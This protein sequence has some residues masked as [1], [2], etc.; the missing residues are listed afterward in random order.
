MTQSRWYR[1]FLRE[2]VQTVLTLFALLAMLG[3][4]S[5]QEAAQS[6]R[7]LNFQSDIT[8]RTDGTVRVRETIEVYA[9]GR[10]IQRGIYR[11]FPTTYQDRFGNRVR[12]RFDVEEVLHNGATANYVVQS[13]DNGSRVR[14]GRGDVFIPE[15]RHTYEI[16]YITDRQLG[17]FEDYDEL[18]WNATGTKWDFPIE[19]AEAVVHLPEGANAGAALG[20][21]GYEGETGADYRVVSTYDG[22]GFATTRVLNPGEGLTI[23]VNWPKGFVTEPSPT[24]RAQWFFRDNLGFAAGLLGLLGLCTYY[25]LSWDRVGRDPRK[26]TIFP[27]YEPPKDLSPAACRF[28]RRMGYDRKAFTAAVI[29][30]AVKGFLRIEEEDGS[31]RLRKLREIGFLR[32][33]TGDKPLSYGEK[34]IARKLLTSNDS[35]LLENENHSKVSGAISSLRNFL[36]D[37]YSDKYFRSNL[38]HFFIGLGISAGL[39]VIAVFFTPQSEVAG[40]LALWLSIWTLGVVSLGNMVYS[41]WKTVITSPFRRLSGLGAALGITAFAAPFFLA[42]IIVLGIFV[43]QGGA[44]LAFLIV[45]VAAVNMIFFHLL[46]AP[47]QFGQQIMDEIEGFRQYLSVAEKHRLNAM[48]GPERTPELFEQYLPYALALDVENEWSEQF[49]D[50]L[51]NAAMDPGASRSSYSPRWYSGS[52]WNQLGSGQFAS[53][54]SSSLGSSVAS[55][56]VAPGSSSGSGGFSS[57]GGGFSGGGGGGGGG[58]GW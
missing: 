37:E 27:R 14:I 50:V 13:L 56:A 18:Y 35:L 52:S 22:V 40:F 7:I 9:A 30:M 46:K 47:T 26:G 48:G 32:P 38:R 20:F 19:Q 29:D 3:S 23:A 42:E 6:E 41:R 34:A 11:D 36:T 28:I 33:D 45:I 5:A 58:G 2:A 54:L 44:A 4:A 25:Y 43:I 57:G 55:S 53:S 10:K 24:Q 21:T 1:A 39:I 31:Y 15:G 49:A 17:F 51:A 16:T 12:V 8:I